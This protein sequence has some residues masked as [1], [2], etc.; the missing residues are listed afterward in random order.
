M[1]GKGGGRKM[2][3]KVYNVEIKNRFRSKEITCV[4]LEV[5]GNAKGTTRHDEGSLLPSNGVTT[6][7]NY[8]CCRSKL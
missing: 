6:N 7:L 3:E 1:S 8:L 4:Q 2:V 5:T